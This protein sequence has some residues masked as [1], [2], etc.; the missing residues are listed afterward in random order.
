MPRLLNVRGDITEAFHFSQHDES[1]AVQTSQ[2]VEPYLNANAK[3]RSHN[4][5]NWQGEMH[6]VASIPFTVIQQWRNELGDDPLAARNRNWFIAK[7]NS[8][9]FNMLRTKEGRI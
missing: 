9:E 6:K 7:L 1:F 4:A 2:D 8:N 5:E 3:D